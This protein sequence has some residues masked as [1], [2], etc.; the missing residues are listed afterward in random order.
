M[1]PI[2]FPRQVLGLFQ[3]RT[4]VGLQSLAFTD[5]ADPHS[6]TMQRRQVVADETTQQ[7]EQIADF[8]RRT[9]PVF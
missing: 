6:V 7:T 2:V 3:E 9:R 5:H 8:A 1:Q 4:D